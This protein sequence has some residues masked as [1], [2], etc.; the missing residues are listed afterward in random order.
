M[1]YAKL[2]SGRIQTFLNAVTS[3]SSEDGI[4]GIYFRDIYLFTWSNKN[5]DIIYEIISRHK[6]SGKEITNL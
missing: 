3:A 1:L 5:I 2:R 6:T 4:T